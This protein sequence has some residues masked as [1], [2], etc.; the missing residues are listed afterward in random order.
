MGVRG[1]EYEKTLYD[2][3]TNSLAITNILASSTLRTPGAKTEMRAKQTQSQAQLSKKISD[4]DK[5]K[6]VQTIIRNGFFQADVFYSPDPTWL[7]DY[8]LMVPGT[9]YGWQTTYRHMD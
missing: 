9:R 5:E 7:Q 8:T 3:A 1:G 6:L 2:S 4:S